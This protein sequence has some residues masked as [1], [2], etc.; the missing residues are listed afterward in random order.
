MVPP[1]ALSNLWAQVRTMQFE[2]VQQAVDALIAEGYPVITLLTQL[3]QDLLTN[4]D[5]SDEQKARMSMMLAETDKQL[6]DGASEYI[7]LLHAA[8]ALTTNFVKS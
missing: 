3:S 8:S 1:A 7:Q 6:I 5:L 4:T 2:N